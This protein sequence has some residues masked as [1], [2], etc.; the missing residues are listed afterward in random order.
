MDKIVIKNLRKSFG[1]TQVLKGIDFTVKKGESLVI[2]GGSG[3]G[4]SIAIQCILGLIQPDAG[5][6]YV[7]GQNIV[8][9]SNQEHRNL[10]QRFGMLFQGGALFDSLP[11]WENITFS[12]LNNRSFSR[13]KARDIALEKLESVGLD[14]TSLD[15]FPAALSGGMKK[16]VGLARAIA[17][18]P[19][20]IF[21]DEP[22]AGL[23][24][25][26]CTVID[27]LIIQSVKT[28]GATTVTITHDLRSI[29]RIADKVAMLYKGSIIWMGPI[30]ALDN[31]ENPYVQQFIHGALNGP[32]T[33]HGC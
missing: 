2:V 24:P 29:H 25:I 31:A 13:Q 28:L 23:D 12:L 3:A 21:F 30:S 22:T 33:T 17:T 8:K 26:M 18:N 19:E 15:K 20:I 4:K 1:N 11:V 7:D 27:S 9:I 5:D 32:F 6:V 10:M 14:A 16:R